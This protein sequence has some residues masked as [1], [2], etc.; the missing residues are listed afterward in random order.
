MAGRF[1][2]VSD[3]EWR[4]FE[5]VFPPAPPKR[6]RGM[7][8]APF[9]KILNTLLYVLITGCR[10]CDVPRAAMGLEECDASLAA[11]LA[12]GWHPGG[13]ASTDSGGGRRN[14]G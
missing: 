3:L 7:P 2:G 8:H 13:H 9:R 5:D 6:G 10:W 1:E 14:A 4:L 11:A 12:G